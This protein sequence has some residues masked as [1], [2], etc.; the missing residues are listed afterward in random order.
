MD[1]L[2]NGGVMAGLVHGTV[3]IFKWR[4]SVAGIAVT[5][6]VVFLADNAAVPGFASKQIRKN[7][8]VT[9]CGL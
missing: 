5:S 8:N 3:R 2:N 7:K 1:D 4:R 6:P 9:L